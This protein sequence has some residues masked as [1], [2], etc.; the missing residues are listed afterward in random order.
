VYFKKS[1]AGRIIP[2]VLRGNRVPGQL[3]ID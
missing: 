1:T 2:Q 3:G